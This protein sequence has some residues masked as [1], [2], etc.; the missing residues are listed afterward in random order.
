MKEGEKETSQ[1]IEQM[2]IVEMKSVEEEKAPVQQ[3]IL[4]K[5]E[6]KKQRFEIKKTT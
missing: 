4:T 3:E 2:K 5:K 1:L 6:A